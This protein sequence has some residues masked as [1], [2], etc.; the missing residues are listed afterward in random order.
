M[1]DFVHSV[2]LTLYLLSEYNKGQIYIV[3]L[4]SYSK[5]EYRQRI[6]T[7]IF[8]FFLFFSWVESF[9]RE[10]LG[11]LLDILEKLISGKM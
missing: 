7:F 6:I 9:G 4:L 10:G 11:L 1:N 5:P 3:A 8:F 2:I